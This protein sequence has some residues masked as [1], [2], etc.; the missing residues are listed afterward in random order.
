MAT[1]QAES[2]QKLLHNF[3]IN[4]DKKKAAAASNG[5]DAST[6]PATDP[7]QPS[8]SRRTAPGTRA[9]KPRLLGASGHSPPSVLHTHHYH[10]GVPPQGSPQQPGSGGGG[11][12]LFHP[13]A[14]SSASCTESSRAAKPRLAV[15]ESPQKLLH[16]FNININLDKKKAAAASNGSDASTPPATD[17]EQPSSSR[18]T[19]PGTR[20][21]KPR[22]LGAS[23]HS[24]PSVLHTHHYDH[25]VPPQGSPQQPGSGG[26]GGVALF[27]PKAPSSASFG[28]G[29]KRGVGFF[30]QKGHTLPACW[31]TPSSMATVQA[32]SPQKLLHNFNININLDKKKAAAASNGSD[33]STPPAT[34]P[35]QPSSSR[36]TA[37]GTRA[38][39]PRLLGASGHSPPSVFHT[40]HYHHG[41]PPQGS[42]QQPGGGGGGGGGVALFH[43]EVGGQPVPSAQLRELYGKF[44]LYQQKL[45][46]TTNQLL[47]ARAQVLRKDEEL[48]ARDQII[49]VLTHTIRA[50]GRDRE[51]K[52][53]ET[54][55]LALEVQSLRAVL[56][57]QVDVAKQM[58]NNQA[59]TVIESEQLRRVIDKMQDAMA[60]DVGARDS[61]IAE[62]FALL[63]KLAKRR[64]LDTPEDNSS[65]PS[66]N[67]GR[68]LPSPGLQAARHQ[69][70]PQQ[71]QQQQQQQQASSAASAVSKCRAPLS[72]NGASSPA[73]RVNTAIQIPNAELSI[74]RILGL[75]QSLPSEVAS[76]RGSQPDVCRESRH[77][78]V[79]IKMISSVSKGSENPGL[80]PTPS[81]HGIEPTDLNGL[82]ATQ[83]Q[84]ARSQQSSL[85]KNSHVPSHLPEKETAT[86]A[87]RA[88]GAVD[89]CSTASHQGPAGYPSVSD[90]GMSHGHDTLD[91]ASLCKSIQSASKQSAIP[92]APVSQAASDVPVPSRTQSL[93]RVPLAL[94]QSLSSLPPDVQLAVAAATGLS[95]ASRP[96]KPPAPSP[97]SS[98]A[99]LSKVPDSSRPDNA[100]VASQW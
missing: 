20:A 49:A 45:A 72:S 30:L 16:N 48:L 17:P 40:H 86:S 50:K 35:E 7:E 22:L 55:R 93:S 2:P 31:S 46:E 63:Q 56:A 79:P 23:G 41:V 73:D 89:L 94:Q 52:D 33:A 99:M 37:P 78:D 71:Q 53:G 96:A 90:R 58:E 27:H 80:T 5:S 8:S 61:V 54:A 34:D 69:R 21:A 87:V 29:K 14:P 25:G 42:P 76:H 13:K 70:Q 95:A 32:E 75:A 44:S 9:A 81:L 60:R 91:I 83:R 100:S 15:A 51:S 47:E 65:P 62:Q 88:C 57:A 19:A 18:R 82:A 4:L 10:H 66:P 1:V 74:E 59:K 43:P 67:D 92:Q 3:N 12:A 26:G 97:H 38:A 77:D 24:P 68:P 39:K 84:H 98:T 28:S 6:P 11:V 85:Y 64:H 36:R